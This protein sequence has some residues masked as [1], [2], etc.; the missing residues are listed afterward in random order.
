[1]K[2]RDNKS[3]TLGTIINF[4]KYKDKLLT[5][6]QLL[7]ND[8]SYVQWLIKIWKGDVD[9]N[10]KMLCKSYMKQDKRE[11]YSYSS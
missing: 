1:M 6:N 4:G 8:P 10:V 11:F 3:L 7:K 9:S 5:I 2:N